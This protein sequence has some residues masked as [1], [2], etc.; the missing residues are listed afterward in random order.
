M[1]FLFC[2]C[3]ILSIASSSLYHKVCDKLVAQGPISVMGVAPK[4]P[5]TPTAARCDNSWTPQTASFARTRKN[6]KRKNPK[7]S[8]IRATPC[9]VLDEELHRACWGSMTM[10]ISSTVCGREVEPKLVQSF[11]DFTDG[12]VSDQW[13]KSHEYH[14]HSKAIAL[15]CTPARRC[16]CSPVWWS[17]CSPWCS[18]SCRCRCSSSPSRSPARSMFEMS[19]NNRGRQQQQQQQQ[20]QQHQQQQQQR[21]QQQHQQQ[22][23]QCQQQQQQ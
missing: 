20:H 9:N 13:W 8:R 14:P 12:H 22:Q 23:Q 17:R 6:E 3:S 21:Q 11:W 5:M 10:T 7:W 18:R 2:I 4:R 1:S 16:S 15:T 19:E